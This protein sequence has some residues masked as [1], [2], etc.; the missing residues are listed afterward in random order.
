MGSNVLIGVTV[1]FV[2]LVAGCG[3]WMNAASSKVDET[4]DHAVKL[5]CYDDGFGDGAAGG[6]K[7]PPYT[8]ERCVEVYTDAYDDGVDGNYDPPT[9]E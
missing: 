9:V 3:L 6:G 1:V 2:L 4:I 8:D 5:V 7:F